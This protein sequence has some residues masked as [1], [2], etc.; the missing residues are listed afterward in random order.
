MDAEVLRRLIGEHRDLDELFGGFLAALARSDPED[1]A[2][3][4]AA[5]DEVL[6][7]HTAEEE[8]LVYPPLRDSKRLAA[9][10][11]EDE[12]TRRARELLLEHVQVRELSGMVVRLLTERRDIDGARRLA[13]SLARRWDAHT[14]RE[15]QEIFGGAGSAP[16]LP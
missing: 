9:V 14:T 2:A 3:A 8:D 1:A 10:A 5:F 13:A 7:R 11:G 4:I 15:E 6:R 12:G 16:T